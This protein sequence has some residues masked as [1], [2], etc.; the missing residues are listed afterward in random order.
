M[1]AAAPASPR[2]LWPWL[3]LVVPLLTLPPVVGGRPVSGPGVAQVIRQVLAAPWSEA[4]PA[5]LPVAKLALLA[6]AVAGLLGRPW[7][8]RVVLGGT[9]AALVTVAALQNA[10]TL[11]QGF[12]FLPGNAVAQVTVAAA[13]LVALVRVGPGTAPLKR[14]RLWVAPLLLL[15]WAYPYEVVAGVVRPGL[16]NLL[17]SGSGVTYCMLTPVLAGVMVLRP[18]A[19]PLTARVAVGVLGVLFGLT[20]AVTWF[21]LAPESWWM[22]VLHLP[23]LVVCGVLT[24]TTWVEWRR[25]VVRP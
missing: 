2:R 13:C 24:V 7:S 8:A 17:T 19:Y 11:P 18:A 5:L 25:A 1:T 16:G 21:V 15:A 20:N 9:A 23:L 3:L 10:A 14:G 22:G 12:A 4:A 6:V